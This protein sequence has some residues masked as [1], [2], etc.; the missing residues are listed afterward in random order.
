[1]DRFHLPLS[2]SIWLVTSIGHFPPEDS[3]SK[4]IYVRE[5]DSELPLDHGHIDRVSRCITEHEAGEALLHRIRR[6]LKLRAQRLLRN[7][8]ELERLATDLFKSGDNLEWT[9]CAGASK[10][11]SPAFCR[12]MPQ[13]QDA[14]FGNVQERDPA[15]RA[16]ARPIDTS[17]RI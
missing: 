12:R 15:H 9:Q 10:F 2:P 7:M 8:L 11:D 1:M 3:P 14:H 5:L 13:S 16:S 17:G 4:L 6:S